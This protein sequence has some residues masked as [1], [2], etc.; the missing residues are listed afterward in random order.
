MPAQPRTDLDWLWRSGYG[1]LNV[2]NINPASAQGNRKATHHHLC[3]VSNEN[4][5]WG[6]D[7]VSWSCCVSD[8]EAAQL[9]ADG[10]MLSSL[11][12]NSSDIGT[13]APGKAPAR[14]HSPLKL[15]C[16]DE[17]TSVSEATVKAKSLTTTYRRTQR[18]KW[19]YR[20]T[21]WPVH[22]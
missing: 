19:R 17:N 16:S 8:V 1:W 13:A 12:I 2:S 4:W 14:R 5:D 9:L 7:S 22:L 6:S 11:L 21:S 18:S 3:V 10:W 20:A 15:A